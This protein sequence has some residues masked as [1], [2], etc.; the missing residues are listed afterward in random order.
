[1]H[2]IRAGGVTLTTHPLPA[3]VDGAARTLWLDQPDSCPL[4]WQRTGFPESLDLDVDIG[5]DATV[6]MPIGYPLA[7]WLLDGPCT[8]HG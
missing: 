8:R 3:T 7:A 1:V 6:T 5:S 4:T 2:S